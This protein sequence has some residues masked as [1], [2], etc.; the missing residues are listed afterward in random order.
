MEFTYKVPR[1]KE[2]EKNQQSKFYSFA[3]GNYTKLLVK[4]DIPLQVHLFWMKKKMCKNPVNKK[5]TE[6]DYY[7]F[8]T[9]KINHLLI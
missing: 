8:S 4:R 9:V 1:E 7:C 5:K 3:P 6:K 2:K